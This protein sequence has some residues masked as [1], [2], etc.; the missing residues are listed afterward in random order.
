MRDLG[1]HINRFS[2]L[3]FFLGPPLWPMEAPRLGVILEMKL[4]AYAT[5]T[6]TPGLSCC[7]C[8]LHHRLQQRWILNPLSETR[9]RT[10]ILVDPSQVLN[11]LSHNR[12][13]S[14]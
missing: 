1:N 5:A 8:D 13:P 4:L 12:N 10:R 2:S 14:Y 6:A 11:L 7:I 3:F 9:D